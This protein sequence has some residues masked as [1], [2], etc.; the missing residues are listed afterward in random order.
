MARSRRQQEQPETAARSRV[1]KSGEKQRRAARGCKNGAKRN[2]MMWG[3]GGCIK[4]HEMSCKEL[5]RCLDKSSAQQETARAARSSSAQQET[6]RVARSSG[7]QR[8]E[9]EKQARGI[10]FLEF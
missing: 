4:Q 9:A 5:P 8:E 3:W 6:A 7:A 1:G 2:A 10:I